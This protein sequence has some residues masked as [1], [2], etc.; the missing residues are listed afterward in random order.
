MLFVRLF[1]IHL[2]FN[3]KWVICFSHIIAVASYIYWDDEVRFVQNLH[4]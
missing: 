4:A 1:F 3:D 2:L